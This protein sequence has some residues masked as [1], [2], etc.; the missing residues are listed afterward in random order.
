MLKINNIIKDINDKKESDVVINQLKDIIISI[1]KVIEENKKFSDKISQEI[2]NLMN[3]MYSKFEKLNNS[4]F[5]S[6]ETKIYNEGKVDD[7][8]YVGEFRNGLRDGKGVIR[9]YWFFYK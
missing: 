6:T 4:D 5:R 1:E 8:K 2:Q 9:R 3:N 7:G